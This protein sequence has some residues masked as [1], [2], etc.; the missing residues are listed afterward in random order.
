MKKF[1]LLFT[2]FFLAA[3]SS[4]RESDTP[5]TD[6]PESVQTI[7]ALGD[8]LTAGYGLPEDQSY[9]AQLERK[10]SE[11]G[12]NYTLENAGISGDTTA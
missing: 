4:G 10:L 11:L 1:I 5:A 6:T 9:P 12:Y 8:S 7:I 3:C 2:F